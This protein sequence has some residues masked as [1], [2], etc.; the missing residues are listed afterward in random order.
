MT[1]EIAESEGA[2]HAS[3]YDDPHVI[4]GNGVG[5]LQVVRDL[6]RERRTISHFF[7]P[8]AEVA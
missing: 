4:A 8:S 1:R 7:A 5:A 3:P 6:L 2:I